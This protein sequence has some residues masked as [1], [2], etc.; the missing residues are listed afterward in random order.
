MP[1]NLRKRKY[2]SNYRPINMKIGGSAFMGKRFRN[3]YKKV[4]KR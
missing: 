2:N 1:Y 4:T 3:G